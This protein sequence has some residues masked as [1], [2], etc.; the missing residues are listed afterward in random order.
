MSHPAASRIPLYIGEVYKPCVSG[1]FLDD[2]RLATCPVESHRVGLS[3]ASHNTLDTQPLF[4]FF[5]MSSD[6]E[7]LFDTLMNK[8]IHQMSGQAALFGNGRLQ[9][10]PTTDPAPDSTL[11]IVYSLL[12]IE[13]R[14]AGFA[15]RNPEELRR[16]NRS[17]GHDMLGAPVLTIE[18]PLRY[19]NRP[20]CDRTQTTP[21]F[22][23][24][25][26]SSR[27]RIHAPT[28]AKI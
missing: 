28:E 1:L 19:R 27:V 11:L 3:D 25:H 22:A 5:L 4:K 8:L 6:N 20:A 2:I 23:R 18:R 16:E 12:I 15:R 10:F 7:A 21:K 13:S 17:N 9:D 14:D 26:G 24:P